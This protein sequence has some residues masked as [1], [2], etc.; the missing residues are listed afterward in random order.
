MEAS[1]CHLPMLASIPT[2][3]S[4]QPDGRPREHVGA[5]DGPVSLGYMAYG[6][7]VRVETSLHLIGHLPSPLIPGA[8][9]GM[10]ESGGASFQFGRVR[11]SDGEA[12]FQVAENGALAYCSSDAAMAV[13]ALES[14]VHH[15]VASSTAAAVFVHA[16]AIGWRGSAAVIPGRSHC[17]KST[18]VAALVKAGAV[19][20]SDEYAVIGLDGRV[21]AFPRRL[22]LRRDVLREDAAPESG[23]C[24]SALETLPIRWVL[25]VRYRA[26]ATWQPRALTPGETLLGLLENAVAVRRQS[27]LTVKTLKAA[28][29][30]TLG[31]QSERGEAAAAAE[32]ITHLLDTEL[33]KGEPY[34]QSEGATR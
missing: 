6:V 8:Q 14:R 17:G 15:Y 31:F 28:I 16:G 1:G 24:A 13:H 27:E 25:N 11:R 20:Y 33:E 22:R 5:S 32:E 34:E 2:T 12:E 3:R 4:A 26:N 29:E 7:P 10:L 18:L 19:Y 21:S 30:G 9:P 23:R